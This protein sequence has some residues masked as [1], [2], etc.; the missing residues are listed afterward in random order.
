MQILQT[1]AS[2]AFEK[3]TTLLTGQEAKRPARKVHTNSL[4]PVILDSSINRER[5]VIR[6]PSAG[7]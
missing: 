1:L 7:T 6:M 3:I 4:S 5:P 2:Q